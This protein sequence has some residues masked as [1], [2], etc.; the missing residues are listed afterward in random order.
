MPVILAKDPAISHLN[1]KPGDLIR[2]RRKSP[3]GG[4]SIFY[5]VVKL[6]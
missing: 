3:T 4:E 5:R 6:E 2:I 1:A